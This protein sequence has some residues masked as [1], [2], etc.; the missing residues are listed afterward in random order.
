MR[1]D[2][3]DDWLNWQQQ[4]NLNSIELGL[5]RVS[6]VYQRLAIK[7]PR[8]V[9]TVAG[10][11]GKGSTVAGYE[12]WLK[13]A[14]FSVA[15][16]TSPHLL[17]Y[18]ERIRKNLQLVSDQELCDAFERIEQVRDDIPLTYFE[19]GTLAALVLMSD[20]AP[21][22][23]ILEV[24]L[25]GRLDAV[26]II[27]AELAH[28]TPVALDHQSW[29]GNDR[30]TIALEKAGIL[31]AHGLAVCSDE[32]PPASVLQ[33]LQEL[34]CHVALAVRDY[35][36]QWIDDTQIQ[37]QGKHHS[38]RL[39]PPLPGAHQAQNVSAVL[40]G[41]ELLGCL[42]G[43]DAETIAARFQGVSCMGRLQTLDIAGFDGR[44]IVDV[45]H[46]QHAAQV[47][48]RY[49]KKLKPQQRVTVILGMLEDKDSVGFATELAE[50]VD[51]WW[52]VGLQ[53]ERGL[54]AQQLFE[55]LADSLQ[56][57]QRF[58]SVDQALTQAM[59]SLGNQDILLVTGSFLTVENALQY[60]E[61][62]S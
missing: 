60:F 15:S 5:D 1:F 6:L 21:D 14:G 8:R 37:W 53:G 29:L 49:L 56:N 36:Y 24:G 42:Q 18:N 44:L 58:E 52:L 2:N 41:L 62:H 61:E 7:P 59:S 35:Q 55:R 54:T 45:G 30:E 25:G 38:V 19:F 46:N 32:D 10:T 16:Y 17:R 3:L 31:R 48:A 20:W 13:N 40:A 26:N 47:I 28:I 22:F 39:T 34:D 11:N 51:E 23:C 50:Q 27:D 43:L 33:R 57:Q 4:L 12:T 9:I